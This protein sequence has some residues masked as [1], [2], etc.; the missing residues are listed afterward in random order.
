LGASLLS[1]S[2]PMRNMV[3]RYS[4]AAQWLGFFALI[5]V[6]W[7]V[8]YLMQ[9][10]AT[11][12]ELLRIYGADFWATLCAPLTGQ[13]P[14]WA[15]L[16]MWALMS[17]AM[18][19]PTFAPTLKTYRDLTHTEAA[20]TQ[21]FF[22]LLAAY[23]TV[24]LGFSVVA[25]G[26]QLL[27]ARQG[28]LGADGASVSLALTSV[29]LLVA[30]GYQFSHAK[31]ACLSK[32]RAPLMF[33]MQHWKPGV[34]GAFR[35]GWTLG[36]VCLGCCWALMTLGFV[37]GVMNL[38]WMGLATLFMAL[39]KLPDIGRLVTKPLGFVLLGAGLV[40]GVQAIAGL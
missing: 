7:S 38:A 22:A 25:A 35:M 19:A 26:A 29:L 27:L 2:P 4:G 8:I 32:C 21:T 5:L 30:G 28:F 33:F 18:M 10:S 20:S 37:G 6:A 24:W 23:L 15:V 1:G 13:S 36:M 39:E 14:Y 40:A 12:A 17:A 31:E 16:S 3:L 9:P 34:T 11:E